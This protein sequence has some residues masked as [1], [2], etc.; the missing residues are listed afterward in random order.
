ML[1]SKTKRSVTTGDLMKYEPLI[2]VGAIRDS[3]KGLSILRTRYSNPYIGP[4]KPAI[5]EPHSVCRNI[6]GAD[7]RP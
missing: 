5:V 7:V 3:P 1:F 2:P 4:L 6:T